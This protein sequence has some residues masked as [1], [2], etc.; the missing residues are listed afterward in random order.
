M[1]QC[2]V[3]VHSNRS[4]IGTPFT[5]K[6]GVFPS[7]SIDS[8]EL[9]EN[10]GQSDRIDQ[11]SR[12]H[13][14]F[15]EWMRLFAEVMSTFQIIIWSLEIQYASKIENILKSNLC[16]VFRQN[17]AVSQQQ[18]LLLIL[19]SIRQAEHIV[20]KFWI[21]VYRSGNINMKKLFV[22]MLESVSK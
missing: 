19:P 6:R 16:I 14:K 7:Q 12:F 11:V 5:A 4:A 21:D 17:G 13:S 22:E 9:W 15:I 2:P 3:S 10:A 1:F 18:H 20:R 8:I